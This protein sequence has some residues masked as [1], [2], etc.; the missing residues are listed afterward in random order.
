MTQ[1]ASGVE[2][3]IPLEGA[4]FHILLAQ[5]PNISDGQ[6]LTLGPLFQSYPSETKFQG[7]KT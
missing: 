6:K 4:K 7:V 2:N 3:E 5:N 1:P